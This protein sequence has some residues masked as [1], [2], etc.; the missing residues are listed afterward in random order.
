MNGGV[1]VKRL[2]LLIVITSML[3]GCGRGPKHMISV[4]KLEA[5]DKINVLYVALSEPYRLVTKNG[6]T[7]LSRI[8]RGGAYYRVDLSKIKV[9]KSKVEE[10]ECITV[11]LPEPSIEAFPDP[12]RSIELK[13]KTK[14]FVNDTGLNR[15]REMYDATDREKIYAAASKPEYVKMAREQTEKILRGMLSG[16]HVTFKWEN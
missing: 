5:M 1:S 2:M 14:W 16:V 8:V 9:N 10:G 3:S 6:K 7:S 13:P 12:T 4:D 11:E 15:I